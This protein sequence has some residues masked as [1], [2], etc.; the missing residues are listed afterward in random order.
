M[1]FDSTHSFDP[2]VWGESDHPAFVSPDNLFLHLTSRG[3][4]VVGMWMQL[5][6]WCVSCGWVLQMNSG[7]GC[8]VASTLCKYDLKK[9]D[10]FLLSWE[11]CDE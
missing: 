9:G 3:N 5:K 11:G 4:S 10:L 8:D 2:C 6:R 1:L 7:V